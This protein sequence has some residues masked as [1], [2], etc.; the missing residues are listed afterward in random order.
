[1]DLSEE[2]LGELRK[3]LEGS[4]EARE[5]L[6]SIVVQTLMSQ[7]KD[8]GEQSYRYF[9][10]NYD[11]LVEQGEAFEA[12]SDETK[13][14]E[15]VAPM[16]TIRESVLARLVDILAK[17]PYHAD[18]LVDQA[19]KAIN[20]AMDMLEEKWDA[21]S[22][23][24]QATFLLSAENL[25]TKTESSFNDA[26]TMLREDT[27]LNLKSA[28]LQGFAVISDSFDFQL[29]D[30]VERF[31]EEMISL[32][33]TFSDEMA[34]YAQGLDYGSEKS[35]RELDLLN[36]KG[37]KFTEKVKQLK[38]A[39][40]DA[41]AELEEDFDDADATSKEDYDNVVDN[42]FATADKESAKILAMVIKKVDDYKNSFQ[43]RFSQCDA[44]LEQ[45]FEEQRELF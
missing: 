32:I 18:Q 10:S 26:L 28:L 44:Y 31:G 24:T 9:Y 23:D 29:D 3:T 33:S 39:F 45:R 43:N 6:L 41:I 22:S 30:A 8:F 40:D 2:I 15:I 36:K 7:S 37:I 12:Q 17:D 35:E 25:R 19:N 20:D 27:D 1:M 4:Q 42:F 38:F 21:F 11:K 13:L 14:D 34:T 5:Q 16:E